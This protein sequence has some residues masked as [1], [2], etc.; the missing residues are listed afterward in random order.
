VVVGVVVMGVVVGLV[1]DAAVVRPVEVP[2]V[3]GDPAVAVEATF[4]PITPTRPASP[5]VASS[6]VPSVA[7]EIRRRPLW[8]MSAGLSILRG[9]RCAIGFS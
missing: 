5:V 3:D 8:R 2:T 4:C 1:A 7:L 9:A 6:V